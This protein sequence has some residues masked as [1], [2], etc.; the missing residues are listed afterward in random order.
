M[1]VDLGLKGGVMVYLSLKSN[2][3]FEAASRLLCLPENCK[4]F[5][6]RLGWFSPIYASY[7]HNFPVMK[8]HSRWQKQFRMWA[9]GLRC[10]CSVQ[11]SLFN[12]GRL[13]TCELRQYSITSPKC[14]K[15]KFGTVQVYTVYLKKKIAAAR[16]LEVELFAGPPNT[17][18]P[19]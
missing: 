6:N 11:D 8:S 5:T 1:V 9:V 14:I 16:R 4:L 10:R 3:N 19:A 2:N 13:V 15:S 17:F 12:T 7:C 18:H